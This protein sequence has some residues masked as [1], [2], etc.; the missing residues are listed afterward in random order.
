MRKTETWEER[1][2]GGER[3]GRDTQTDRQRWR[4]RDRERVRKTETWEEREGVGERE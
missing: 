3:V 1:E 2:G 4:Q